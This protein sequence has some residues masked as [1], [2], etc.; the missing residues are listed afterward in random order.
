MQICVQSGK[1]SLEFSNQIIA[2]YFACGGWG[3]VEFGELKLL[4]CIYS[5]QPAGPPLSVSV[6][7]NMQPS[8]SRASCSASKLIMIYSRLSKLGLCH[9]VQIDL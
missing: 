2:E 8:P 6:H 7:H 3:V 4:S 1:V 5:G 9:C